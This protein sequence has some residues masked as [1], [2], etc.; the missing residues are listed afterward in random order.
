M[1]TLRRRAVGLVAPGA[2]PPLTLAA[3]LAVY[4]IW[5]STYFGIRLAIDTIPPLLMSGV[6]F[7]VAGL[8][9]CAFALRHRA[10]PEAGRIRTRLPSLAQCRATLVVGT[11]LVAVGNGGVTLAEEAVPSGVVALLIATVPLWMAFLANCFLGERLRPAAWL[12]IA[13]GLAGVA[14]LLRPGGGG[15]R[16]AMLAVLVSPLCWAAG[17]L[18]ARRADLPSST[19]LST[20]MEMLF[21]GAVLLAVGLIRGEAGRVHLG[22]F[23]STSVLAFVYLVLI[24]SIIGYSSYV[25]ILTA[26]PTA[27]VATYA[28]VNP[29]VAVALGALFLGEVVRGQT[30]VAGGLIVVAVALILAQPVRRHRPGDV[31]D[32]LP[33]QRAAA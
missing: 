23:S 6:R 25:F 24:G 9:M 14:L 32:H 5:G 10:T 20:G 19:I 13:V 27:V 11:A 33:D 7:M 2:S 8:L 26:L 17:S 18:Y 4:V 31:P 29:L 28:Y 12:G 1:T 3:L 15:N 22:A 21:G 30:L 16:A